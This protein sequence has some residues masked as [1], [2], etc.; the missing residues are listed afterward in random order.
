MSF[1][2]NALHACLKT[3]SGIL[4]PNNRCLPGLVPMD[5]TIKGCGPECTYDRDCYKNFGDN[6]ECQSQR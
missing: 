3:K 1:M 2:L 5:D 6:Y 4:Y